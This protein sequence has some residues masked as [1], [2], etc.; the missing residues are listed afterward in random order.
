MKGPKQSRAHQQRLSKDESR[1][2]FAVEARGCH[3]D[4]EKQ[5][6]QR[7]TAG[8]TPLP[9]VGVDVQVQLAFRDVRWI[10]GRA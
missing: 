3:V 10:K 4:L 1:G 8:R 2:G 7:L 9:R 6:L 5:H